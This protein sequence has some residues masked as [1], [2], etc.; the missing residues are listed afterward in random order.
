MASEVLNAAF[1]DRCRRVFC[2]KGGPSRTTSK[3]NAYTPNSNDKLCLEW[4]P[5]VES[6]EASAKAGCFLCEDVWYEFL[7]ADMGDVRRYRFDVFIEYVKRGESSLGKE[8]WDGGSNWSWFYFQFYANMEGEPDVCFSS[9]C[10]KPP[11][12][13]AVPEAERPMADEKPSTRDLKPAKQWLKQ[14]VEGHILCNQRSLHP[15]ALPSRL[16]QLRQEIGS[17]KAR[18]VNSRDFSVDYSYVTLSHC[19]GLGPLYSLK[20][21][22]L[23]DLRSDIPISDLPRTFRD[24]F[25]VAFR[26][27]YTLI[28]IDSLCII[29]DSPSDWEEEL[30]KMANIYGNA[31]CC[32][33]AIVSTSSK[34]GLYARNERSTLSHSSHTWT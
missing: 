20:S 1:C 11:A 14:C 18:L 30:G 15:G 25:E 12:T 13:L 6:L 34:G 23:A 17:L 8:G 26:L 22:L 27:D 5:S 3:P 7:A 10:F 2:A 32:I 28:W 19:W 21:H 29:Q 4:Q 16:I 31:S 24:A 9:Y 33:A